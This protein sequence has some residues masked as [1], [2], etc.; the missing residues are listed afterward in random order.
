[1]AEDQAGRNIV[2]HY[3]GTYY[4][5]DEHD[6]RPKPVAEAVQQRAADA[7]D[8]G[9]K[10]GRL[11]PEES[12]SRLAGM[13]CF[14]ADLSGLA[15]GGA[16]SSTSGTWILVNGDTSRTL[17]LQTGEFGELPGQLRP[18]VERAIDDGMVVGRLANDA[19]SSGTSC[20]ILNLGQF[21]SPGTNASAASPENIV[22][23]HEGRY[24]H[25]DGRERRVE[26]PGEE[27]ARAAERAMHDGT[28][29]GCLCFLA[30]VG[31]MATLV[32]LDGFGKASTVLIRD[33]EGDLE[34][35]PLNQQSIKPVRQ[36]ALERAHH[37]LA[38]GVQVGLVQEDVQN[39]SCYLLDLPALR[40]RAA[41]E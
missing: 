34:Q 18:I 15:D 23:H 7:I 9:L 22:L 40:G 39:G 27:L 41:E 16:L 32:D 25:L 13:T 12:T 11:P 5:W 36:E 14:V 10:L 35:L 33:R 3:K 6:W 26:V 28:T 4:S 21:A 37:A 31:C 20:V 24:F 19:T 38:L 17:D 2:L 8:A 29:V 30:D 1:M